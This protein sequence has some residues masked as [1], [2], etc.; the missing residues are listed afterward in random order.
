MQ[1]SVSL[2]R[3]ENSIVSFPL[4][5]SIPKSSPLLSIIKTDSGFTLKPENS[6]EMWS[7][8]DC[9]KG[10]IAGSKGYK[11]NISD[12]VKLGRVKYTVKDIS[13]TKTEFSSPNESQLCHVSSSED[14]Q[15]CRICLVEE[16]PNDPLISPCNCGGT[17]KFI[18]LSCFK[19]WIESR[20]TKKIAE[21]SVSYF[22]KS[23]TCEISRCPVL[24][25]LV[26]NGQDIDLLDTKPVPAPYVVLESS[27]SDKNEYSLHHIS[28]ASKNEVKLGRGHDSDI[29]ISDISV[30][31]CHAILKFAENEFVLEDNS[32]K[33]GTLV[34]NK[35]ICID[36]GNCSACIQVGRTLLIFTLNV[37]DLDLDNSVDET[38][39]EQDL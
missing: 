38:D 18:H 33:F 28:M 5:S 39:E 9:N 21:P 23:L 27:P 6:S 17:M 26:V 34:G 11:L 14:S 4:L 20:T 35:E 15:L 22:V 19:K 2:Y 36:K 37:G 1:D 16:E 13:L 8:I 32:S 7:V 30:S 25:R 12:T 31:R 29:R 3:E 10:K 24:P